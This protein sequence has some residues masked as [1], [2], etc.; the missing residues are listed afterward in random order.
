VKSSETLILSLPPEQLLKFITTLIMADTDRADRTYIF[1]ELNEYFYSDGGSPDRAMDCIFMMNEKEWELLEKAWKDSPTKW[2]E[3]CTY[4]L[5]CGS[6]A[7]CMT[8]LLEVALFDENIDVIKQAVASIAGLLID[9]DD[10]Y[11]PPVYLNDE[12]VAQMRYIVELQDKYIEEETDMLENLHRI[13]DDK[14]KFIPH[15]SES[16]SSEIL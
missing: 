16:T 10:E 8:M 14:W 15:E 1:D 4:I 12:M 9:R 5:G 3:N 6:I 11:D 2:R 13:S 7:D